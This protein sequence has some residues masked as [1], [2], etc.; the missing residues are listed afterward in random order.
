MSTKEI[1]KNKEMI[2]EKQLIK[3]EVEDYAKFD[4]LRYAQVWED[5]DILLQALDIHEDDNILSCIVVFPPF[6]SKGYGKFMIA[7]SY[8]LARREGKMGSPERPLSDLG[9][10]AFHG[11]WRDTIVEKWRQWRGS[12]ASIDDLSEITWIAK[13]DLEESLKEQGLS[14]IT[15]EWIVE[16]TGLETRPVFAEHDARPPPISQ[17]NPRMLIWIPDTIT[18]E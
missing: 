10:R 9:R 13:E 15:G 3:S 18:R 2:E 11:Y 12:I 7:L 5:A 14:D 1:V 4:I 6:Q 17:F 8:E 16:L